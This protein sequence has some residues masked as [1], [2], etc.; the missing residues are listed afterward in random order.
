MGAQGAPEPAWVG[1][2]EGGAFC[3]LGAHR[4]Q[5]KTCFQP[6]EPSQA[7]VRPL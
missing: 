7:R 3:A 6:R 1:E 2:G 5:P 4:L